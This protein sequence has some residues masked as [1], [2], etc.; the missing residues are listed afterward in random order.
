MSYRILCDENVAPQTVRYLDREGH[1]AVHVKEGLSTGADDDAVVSYAREHGR[2]VLTN[3]A[4][5]LDASQAKGV[6]VLY[7]PNN[8]LSPYE[9][10]TLVD[11]VT[12]YYPEQSALP[13]TLFLSEENVG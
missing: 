2:V 12:A 3:D 8:R 6:P 1:D 13:A 9:L 11:E 4:D 7:F 5:F 10:A